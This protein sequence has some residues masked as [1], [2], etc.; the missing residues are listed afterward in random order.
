MTRFRVTYDIVTPE[1]A[2]HGDTAESGFVI[3]GGWKVAA[4]IGKPTPGVAMGLR[5]ALDLASPDCDCGTWFSESDGRTDYKTGA[6]ETR[7]IH[8]PANVSP[9][10]Y[11]RLARLMGVN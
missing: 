10:S 7:S 3:A 2:E 8:P 9:S 5:A 11:R 1:S 6:Q 4:E